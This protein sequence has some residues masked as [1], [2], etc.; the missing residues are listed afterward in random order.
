M[1]VISILLV[2]DHPVVREG[3]RRLLE[4]QPDFRVCAEADDAQQAYQRYKDHR[5]D[6]VVMDLGLPGAGGLEAL[7]HIREWDKQARILVFTMHLGAA[8]ALKAFEAGALGYVTK[9]SE[10]GELLKA[11]AAAAQGRRFL[12][13]DISRALAADRLG[14]ANRAVEDLGPRETEILRLLASGFD[15]ETIA[16][17]LNLSHKTVR[18]HHYAIKSKIGARNDAHLVWIAVRAGLVSIED[19]KMAPDV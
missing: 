5:P 13:E 10:P 7:R 3:Y 6:V 8:F 4:R 2:D 19:A 15:S 14:G 1:S 11:V 16:E 12:S 18:N 17:L 9:S